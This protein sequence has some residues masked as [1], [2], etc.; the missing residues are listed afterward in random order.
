MGVVVFGGTGGLGQAICRDFARQGRKVAFTFRTAREKAATLAQSLG[1]DSLHDQVDL[2][3]ADAVVAF[4]QR[5]K[6]KFGRVEAVVYASGPDIAQPYV[7]DITA[8][9]IS[10]ASSMWC[11]PACRCSGRRNRG[12]WWR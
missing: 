8:E 4:V 10:T 11:R 1:G 3:R 6:E 7:G 5:A 9:Q 2:T 12:R